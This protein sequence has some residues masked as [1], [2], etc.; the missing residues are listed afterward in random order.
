[1]DS[2]FILIITAVS[3]HQ[4][5]GQGPPTEVIG[6]FKLM[7]SN[8]VNLTQMAKTLKVCWV[9]DIPSFIESINEHRRTIRF[10]KFI[11]HEIALVKIDENDVPLLKGVSRLETYRA[12]KHMNIGW[13]GELP[14]DYYVRL[15]S[16]YPLVDLS[17]TR[18]DIIERDDKSLMIRL[19]PQSR[20]EVLDHPSIEY[21]APWGRLT[22][23]Q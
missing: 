6:N 7:I 23:P 20:L 21:L 15:N 17:A 19:T 14:T 13:V 5:G 3:H 2:S 22:N 8:L 16:K 10:R 18:I 12:S 1:M 9:T 4:F 11:V